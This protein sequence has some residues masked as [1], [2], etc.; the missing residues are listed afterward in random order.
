[1][2]RLMNAGQRSLVDMEDRFS[3]WY[4]VVIMVLL[5]VFLVLVLTV[6]VVSA[7]Q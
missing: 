6:T 2:I 1:M 3:R 5:G 4:P 7:W